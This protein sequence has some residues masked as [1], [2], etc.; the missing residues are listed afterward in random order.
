[1]MPDLTFP[2]DSAQARLT[3]EEFSARALPRL[4]PLT[5]EASSGREAT[6]EVVL[7]GDHRLDDARPFILD[8]ANIRPAAVLIPVV[9]RGE[10]T[11]L[12][13]ERA[14]GLAVHAGQ[15]A[16][17]GGRIEEGETPLAAAL[18]EA[19]EEIGLEPDRVSPLGALAPYLTG[20]GFRVT[21]I[22][23]LVDPAHHLVLNPNEVARVFE[24]PLSF[25]MNPANHEVRSREL[26][27]RTRRFYAMPWQ[28]HD[29]WGAT[30]GMIRALYERVYGS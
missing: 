13:T 29:I 4:L 30:A 12:L 23:A 6:Q 27:G 11:L 14:S 20:T 2:Q 19:H 1:M 15:V 10:A 9:A 7:A 16:F 25:L 26:R 17:P 18:R 3:A 21:P 22:V 24:P 8:P 28:G 5:E